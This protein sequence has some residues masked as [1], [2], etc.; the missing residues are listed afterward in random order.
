MSEVDVLLALGATAMLGSVLRYLMPDLDIAD[1]RQKLNRL[2]LAVFLPALNFKVIYGAEVTGAFWQV[3]VL[4]LTGLFV[5]VTAGGVF[6][7]LLPPLP[8][9]PPRPPL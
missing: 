8:P 2:V 7:P 3:P 5:T 6:F 1:L 4:A 9:P